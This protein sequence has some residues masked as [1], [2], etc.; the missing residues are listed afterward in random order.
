MA[1]DGLRRAHAREPR[2]VQEN[3]AFVANRERDRLFWNNV[4]GQRDDGF[5]KFAGV[6]D[7]GGVRLTNKLHRE[8]GLRGLGI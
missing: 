1:S 2:G 3:D 4:A 6:V 7:I 5:G 8:S